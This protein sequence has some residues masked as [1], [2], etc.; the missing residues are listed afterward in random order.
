MKKKSIGLGI[1]AF[2][3]ILELCPYGAVLNFMGD[4][5][6][7]KSIRSTFSY[8]DLRPFGYA[9]FGPFL[10]AMLSLLA[11]VFL[12]GYLWK[13]SEKLLQLLQNVSWVAL[14]ASK[15][16][17]LFGIRYYSLVGAVISLLLLLSDFW[18]R[19]MKE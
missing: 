1:W 14:F 5:E 2:I 7:G 3:L 13:N 10:T 4:P 17:L 19:A 12:L 8:F 18:C 16:P 6:I 9:N 11:I 15:T